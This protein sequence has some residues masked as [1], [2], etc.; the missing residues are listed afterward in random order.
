LQHC[1]DWSASVASGAVRC[2]NVRRSHCHPG[3]TS[4]IWLDLLVGFK[5]SGAAPRHGGPGSLDRPGVRSTRPEPAREPRCHQG[6]PG[7]GGE[8][9]GGGVG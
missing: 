5:P 1:I 4:V 3:L 9:D 2:R 6:G 7:C 8:R